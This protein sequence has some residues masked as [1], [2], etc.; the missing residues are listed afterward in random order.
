[1]VVG[2]F[3]FLTSLDLFQRVLMDSLNRKSLLILAVII[4]GCAG[5]SEVTP[6]EKSPAASGIPVDD[7]DS[8]NERGVNSSG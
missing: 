1:M 8:L 2:R 4:H 7:L 6:L 5:G 3:L